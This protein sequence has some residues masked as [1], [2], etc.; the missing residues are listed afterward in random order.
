MEKT[1]NEMPHNGSRLEKYIKKSGKMATVVSK[2]MGYSAPLLWRMFDT[3]SI[4]THI[5]WKLGIILNRNIFAEFAEIFPVKY[6]SEREQQLED[7]LKEVKKELEI[8]RRILDKHR[9]SE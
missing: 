5:W 1:M 4:R 3:P 6:K 7:E 2:Q 9:L 8:Y